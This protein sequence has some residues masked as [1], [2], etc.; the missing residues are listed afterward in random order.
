MTVSEPSTIYIAES[1]SADSP[2]S[3]NSSDSEIIPIA[4]LKQTDVSKRK[5][6]DEPAPE[7]KKRGKYRKK[8]PNRPV[9]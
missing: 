4:A 9:K 8:D 1:P 6:E 5:L 2:C 3:N 7:R